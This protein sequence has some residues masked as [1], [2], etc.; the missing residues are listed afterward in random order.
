MP[1]RVPGTTHPGWKESG[2]A[3]V[4]EVGDRAFIA[5]SLRWKEAALVA[6]DA[7]EIG[8]LVGAVDEVDMEET[9]EAAL[10]VEDIGPEG[11]VAS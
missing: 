6:V 7:A 4:G 1:C 11:E 8:L 9:V 3:E 5:L 2:P 10:M